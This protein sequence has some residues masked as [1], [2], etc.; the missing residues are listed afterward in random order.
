MLKLGK[1]QPNLPQGET[2][3]YKKTEDI[4]QVPLE[5]I[6]FFKARRKASLDIR[7][8]T[9]K[10]FGHNQFLVR[11]RMALKYSTNKIKAEIKFT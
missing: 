2:V 9:G 4:F 1:Q 6:D 3:R 7:H 5:T 8:K 10:Q 11:R